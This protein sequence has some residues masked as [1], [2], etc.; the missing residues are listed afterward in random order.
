MENIEINK[1]LISGLMD[2]LNSK[3]YAYKTIKVYKLGLKKLLKGNTILNKD[4]VNRYLKKNKHPNQRAVIS[5]VN[6]YCIQKG[7]DFN[8][9]MPKVKQKPRKLPD[10]LSIEEIKLMVKATPPPYNLMLRCVFGM[11]AGLRISEVIKLSWENIR[12]V[13][14]LANKEYG[15]VILKDTKRD[16]ERVVNIPNELMQDLYNYAKEKNNLNEFGIPRSGQVFL[17][18]PN[19]YK[20]DLRH[21]NF[22][23]WKRDYLDYEYDWIRYNI[24]N[25]CCSKA[26]NK[27]IHVH[28]LRHSRATYLYE[29]EKIPIERI[30]QL[31]GHKDLKTT[32]I[33][34]RIDPRGTF[35]MMKD[36]KVI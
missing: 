14:W 34:T 15:V 16:T 21:N 11:G 2:Y 17:I 5:I 4:L 30:Q 31:L 12:W 36:T 23:Q 32:M 18:K 13:E 10:I 29:V 9:I 3:D 28:M 22:E 24:I 6:E 8:I 33:Y 1:D 27:K 26:L 19:E 25:K 7:I 35:N 20:P